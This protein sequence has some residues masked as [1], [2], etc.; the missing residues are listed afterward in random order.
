MTGNGGRTGSAR[1]G[2][3]LV[4]LVIGMTITGLLAMVLGGMTLAIQ[5]GATHVAGV[6]DASQ[7]AR[8]GLERWRWMVAQA[9]TYQV[10]GQ[11][12]TVGLAIVSQ[13]LGSQL[14]PDTLVVW[15]GGR[16]GGMAGAGL[17]A[18]LPRA[19]E[20]VIYA[21]DATRPERWVEVT[22][23]GNSQSVDFR[24]A[25]FSTTIRSLLT[26]PTASRVLLCDRVRTVAVSSSQRVS[27]LRFTLYQVPSDG[28]LSGVSSGSAAWYELTWAGGVATGSSGMRQANIGVELPIE[29]AR[30]IGSTSSANGTSGEAL[31]NGTS[32]SANTALLFFGSAGVRY[33]YRP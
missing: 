12:S 8:V 14:V 10:S 31:S 5:Q 16:D 20:L 17:Q 11:S 28:E 23:P 18:R 15:S 1:S 9:G 26:T 21:P 22:F 29:R 3:T 32:S 19:S 4:E 13:A 2:L 30:V 6:A 7:Q 33:V 25:N 27:G 24:D